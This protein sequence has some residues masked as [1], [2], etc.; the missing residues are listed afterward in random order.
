MARWP[1][2]HRLPRLPFE[3]LGIHPDSFDWLYAGTGKPI[4]DVRSLAWRRTA[5]VSLAH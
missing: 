1:L 3:V 5:Q 2:L 4:P